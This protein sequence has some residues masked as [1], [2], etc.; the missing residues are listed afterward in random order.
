MK[1]DDRISKGVDKAMDQQTP[2]DGHVEPGVSIRMGPVEP[3]DVDPP[4]STNG[5]RKARNSLN[6]N[7]TY[8]EA[9]SSSEDEKP[10]VRAQ[11]VVVA[12]PVC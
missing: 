12:F 10:L 6:A 9:S 4:A 7:K 11:L 8:R 1:S 5:K 3:M 2:S